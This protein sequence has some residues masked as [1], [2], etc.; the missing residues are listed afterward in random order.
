MDAVKRHDVLW[1]EMN[2]SLT[3]SQSVSIL[4]ERDG[5]VIL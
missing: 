3:G 4:G 2:E 5:V 1:S